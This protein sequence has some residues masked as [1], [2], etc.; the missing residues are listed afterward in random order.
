MAD[1][2]KVRPWSPP[3]NFLVFEQRWKTKIVATLDKHGD[4]DTAT[5]TIRI[6]EDECAESIAEVWFHEL[7]HAVW[8]YTALREI[9][10]EEQQEKI[11][12]SL[13]PGLYATLK[14]N[15]I[16]F[17]DVPAEPQDEGDDPNPRR[18]LKN[19]QSKE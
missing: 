4:T 2:R 5:N 3:D 12:A 10:T 11:I 19:A 1:K 18:R 16:A 14:R 7:A 9:F 17:L 15:G 8:D 13:M 6:S